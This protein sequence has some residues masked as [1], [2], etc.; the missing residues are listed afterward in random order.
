[1]LQRILT[2]QKKHAKKA[3]TDEG[4]VAKVLEEMKLMVREL[5]MRLENRMFEGKEHRPRKLRRFNPML[6]EELTQMI[7]RNSKD[8]I[9]ILIIASIIRDDFPWLYEIGVE[10][11]RTAKD[12]SISEAEEAIRMFRDATEITV[13]GPFMEACGLSSK[14]MHMNMRELPMII[15]HY[16]FRLEKSIP[17]PMMRKRIKK[18]DD[19]KSR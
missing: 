8:P 9:G 3:T 15:D 17:K 5:P 1:M 11:Y 10:A 7:S 18:N 4:T 19:D 14:E 12:G 6:I 16:I 2:I 13:S